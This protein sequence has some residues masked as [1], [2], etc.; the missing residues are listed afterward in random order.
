MRSETF[1]LLKW[2]CLTRSD[3]QN[4]S[5]YERSVGF[6]HVMVFWKFYKLNDASRQSIEAEEKKKGGGGEETVM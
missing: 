5:A 4:T 3:V 1:I 2:L 6:G